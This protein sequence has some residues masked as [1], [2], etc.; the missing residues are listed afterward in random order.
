MGG[1]KRKKPD[2]VV[3]VLVMHPVPVRP[4]TSMESELTGLRSTGPS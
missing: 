4:E 3:C 1:E 2:P